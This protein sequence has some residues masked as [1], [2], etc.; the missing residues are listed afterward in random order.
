MEDHTQ[1]ISELND[2]VAAGVSGVSVDGLNVQAD[3]GQAKKSLREK[4]LQDQSS[5]NTKM[6]RPVVFRNTLGGAW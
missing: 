2:L 3:I 4:M 1:E 6:V 5:I